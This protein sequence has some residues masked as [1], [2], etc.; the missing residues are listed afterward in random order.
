MALPP[1]LA[2]PKVA[3]KAISEAV[4]AEHGNTTFAVAQLHYGGEWEKQRTSMPLETWSAD[5]VADWMHRIRRMPG[6]VD[7]FLDADVDGAKLVQLLS[8]TQADT[9]KQLGVGDDDRIKIQKAVRQYVVHASGDGGVEGGE[10]MSGFAKLMSMWES[11]YTPEVDEDCDEEETALLK[12]VR[13]QQVGV[14]KQCVSQRGV[15]DKVAMRSMLF[16]ASSPRNATLDPA[17]SSDRPATKHEDK[18]AVAAEPAQQNAAAAAEP[19]QEN[20]AAAA[21]LAQNK[22]GFE[23]YTEDELVECLELIPDM[24]EDDLYE[25]LKDVG[26]PQPPGSDVEAMREELEA[27][28]TKRL[29]QVLDGIDVPP[30]LE[31]SEHFNAESPWVEYTDDTTGKKYYHNGTRQPARLCPP[32][33]VVCRGF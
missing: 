12:E 18:K 4:T 9:W 15:A 17:A 30:P 16:G 24:V 25:A 5:H 2:V 21:E 14:C 22:K 23:D 32:P 7:A 29:E 26:K 8:P 6:L 19:E 31:E 1:R 3:P 28:Y 27:F 13:Q 11:G 33:P 10:E 20:A